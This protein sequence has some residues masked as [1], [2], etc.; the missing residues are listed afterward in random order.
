MSA[1]YIFIGPVGDRKAGAVYTEA[2]VSPSQGEARA[3]RSAARPEA[4][5][6]EAGSRNFSAEEKYA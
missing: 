4:F 5:G 1:D 6:A 3:K 2:S